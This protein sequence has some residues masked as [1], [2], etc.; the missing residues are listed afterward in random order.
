[1]SELDA[2][3]PNNVNLSEN[4]KLLRA[5]ESWQPE[6][7]DWWHEMGPEGFQG[8]DIYLRRYKESSDRYDDHRALDTV[9]R[10]EPAAEKS[11][12]AAAGCACTCSEWSC[13]AMPRG[14]TDSPGE[15]TDGRDNKELIPMST[16]VVL[17]TELDL[18]L[19]H[20]G[21]VRDI[22]EVDDAL[23]F[24]ASD[25]LSAFDVVFNEGIPD[26]GKVL[27]HV[28]DFWVHKLQACQPF[29]LKT[30]DVRKMGPQATDH[31]AALA[32]RSML[33]EKLEMLPVECVVR[34]YLVGSGWKDYR[35]TGKVCDH[36]LAQGLNQ[37]DE[38]TEPLFTPAT[39]AELGDH[40]E[41][42][43]FDKVVEL[44]GEDVANEIR[45]RSIRIYQQGRSY[46]RDRGLLLVDT[47]F[48]FGRRSDGTIV[49]A[50]EVLTPDSSRYWDVDEAAATPRGQTPP[51]FDKQIVR[52]YLETLDWGKRPPPPPLPDEII[53][54]TAARYRQLVER[55]TG[56]PLPP[57]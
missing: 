11:L 15:A 36:A 49:L 3:I 27:T 50:D 41:N 10:A 30:L 53:D 32:G 46:A 38:L 51:S 24:I 35:A 20:R 44:V 48:E 40:D 6:Y 23:L 54:R 22:Y 42:I 31:A 26:K 43:S 8:D 1:M 28:T 52:D 21:K 34:G 13:R 55:L 57:R 17:N 33:V 2:R 37:G 9:D 29:H 45:E 12:A 5:L 14:S 7:L 4:R 25:R 19:V 56:S 18:P 47:K 16:D 39:K